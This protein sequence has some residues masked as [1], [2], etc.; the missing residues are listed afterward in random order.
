VGLGVGER[1]RVGVTEG[2]GEGRGELVGVSEGKLLVGAAEGDGEGLGESVGAAVGIG[3][4]VGLMVGLVV[5]AG[6]DSDGDSLGLGDG[7]AVGNTCW[8]GSNNS[9]RLETALAAPPFLPMF[10]KKEALRPASE[11]KREAEALR[12]NS[13]RTIEVTFILIMMFV[14]D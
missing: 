3:A 12:M 6:V 4:A 11:R 5:G 2:D 7:A 1:E 9:A 10:L 8:R 13:K 14:V